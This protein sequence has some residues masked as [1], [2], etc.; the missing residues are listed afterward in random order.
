MKRQWIQRRVPFDD[1]VAD[2]LNALEKEGYRVVHVLQQTPVTL[3]VLAV[4]D[5]K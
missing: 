3:M 4:K 5:L 2:T 1:Q